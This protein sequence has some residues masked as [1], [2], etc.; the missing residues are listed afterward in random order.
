MTQQN[1]R[2]NSTQ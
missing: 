1:T 2:L